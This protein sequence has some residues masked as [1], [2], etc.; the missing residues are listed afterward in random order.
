MTKK[1]NAISN[2]NLKDIGILKAG[3]RAK[4]LIHL[5]EIAGLFLF[6]LEK[7]IIYSNN[8]NC[9]YLNS[10]NKFLKKCNCI[11]YLNNFI[12][13]GYWN[14]EL[15]FSQMLSKVPI[16]KE[17]LSKDFNINNE[18]DL[19]KIMKGLEDESK[20]YLSK[21][22]TLDRNYYSYSKPN[23]IYSCESCVIF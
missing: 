18:S 17:N 23:N 1:G 2:Q 8:S 10:L 16:N 11:K 5:E 20:I 13:N 21:L 15:L 3:E 12:I 22:K 19:D 6:S 14:S 7:N 4:I 9:K